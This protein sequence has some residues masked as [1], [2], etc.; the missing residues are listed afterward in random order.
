LEY[1]HGSEDPFEVQ[2]SVEEGT[3]ILAAM[4]ISKFKILI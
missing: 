4:H 1:E 2:A 3:V